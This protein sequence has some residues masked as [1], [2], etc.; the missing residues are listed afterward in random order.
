MLSAAQ[1]ASGRAAEKHPAGK[2]GTGNHLIACLPDAVRALWQPHLEVVDFVPNQVLYAS[3]G[4]LPYVY[5]PVST[6]VSL[7][8][9]SANGGSTEIAVIGNEGMVGFALIMGGNTTPSSAVA[10]NAGEAFRLKA[11]F[12]KQDFPLVAPV[13]HLLLRFTQAL[14]TQMAQTAVCNRHHCLEQQL[15]R[16]LLLSLDRLPGGELLMTHEALASRLGVRREGV[17]ESAA[18]LQ[19]AGVIQ[20]ARGHIRVLDRGRLEAR[21]CECYGVVRKEYRRLLPDR[22]VT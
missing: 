5:F 4:L 6:L 20:Y 7:Q 16:C 18:R 9:A 19:R 11:Q 1:Q 21:S 15:C 10:Q 2:Q 14:I 22:I 3:E 8:Y 17:T 13:T 12:V